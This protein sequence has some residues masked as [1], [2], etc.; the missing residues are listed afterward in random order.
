MRDLLA[1]IGAFSVMQFIYLHTDLL[2]HVARAI[3][4]H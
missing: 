4:L 2:Q 1:I 3:N